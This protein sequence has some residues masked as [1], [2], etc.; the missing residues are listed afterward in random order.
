MTTLRCHVARVVAVAPY[1][2][3]A[4]IAARRIIAVVATKFVQAE[5]PATKVAEEPP[6]GPSVPA[7][8]T[9][10]SVLVREASC[11]P[12]P[13]DVFAATSVYLAPE[14]FKVVEHRSL[15]L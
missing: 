12:R 3:V 15:L 5:P 7:I 10:A 8:Y 6:V 9:E 4:W 1:K 13:A 14:A 2:E 11:R